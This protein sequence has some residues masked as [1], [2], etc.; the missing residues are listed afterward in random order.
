MTTS[1]PRAIRISIHAMGGEGG[2]VLADWLVDLGE[3]NGHIAQLTSV[4]GVAQRTGATFYYIELFPKAGLG[5]AD[6]PVLALM[7]VP[8]DVDLVI[9]SE[10]ME[11]GRA[12]QRGLVTPDRTTLI[13]STNRVYAMTERVEMGDGRVNEAKLLE[14]CQLAAKR[15]VVFDMAEVAAKSGSVISAVMFGA[16]AGAGVLPFEREAY[17]ATIARGGVGVAAST[18]AF[19]A[20]YAAARGPV[21]S[22]ATVPQ[23]AATTETPWPPALAQAFDASVLALPAAVQEIARE[24][25]RRLCD[26]QDPAYAREYLARLARICEIDRQRPASSF[27]LSRET[28]RYLALAM[29]Y[30]DTIRVAE[31]KT[32]RDRFARVADEVGVRDGQVLEVREYLHPRLQ[33]IA[34]SVPA[35]IGRFLLRNGLARGLVNSLTTSGKTVATTS[36]RGFLLL[37]GVSAMKPYRR[38]TLRYSEEQASIERWLDDVR[39]FAASNY[40]LACEIVECRNLIKGYGDTLERGRR[41]YDAIVTLARGEMATPAIDRAVATLRTAALADDSGAKLKAAIARFSQAPA[42]PAD[43]PPHQANAAAS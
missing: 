21:P 27:R 35:P 20:A 14:A 22:A 31:L 43:T 3:Q 36:L 42:T 39:A 17:I 24:G 26:Y 34:E 19:D 40:D 28:A 32:R 33:E 18:K 5:G 25:V 7:P 29:S 16:V 30:E 15:L 4:P 23:A 38:S 2:G 37:Y 9:A 8:G 11:A 12:I 10:L 6:A 13:A 1:S 41:N